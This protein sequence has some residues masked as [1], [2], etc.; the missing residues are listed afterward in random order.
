MSEYSGRAA[1]SAARAKARKPS[2]LAVKCVELKR[3]RDELKNALT[4]MRDHYND[5]SKSNPGFM[6]KLVIQDY[7]LWNRALMAMD[8]ALK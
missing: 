6:G 7:A 3:E 1:E 2:K 8:S 4:L 5:L